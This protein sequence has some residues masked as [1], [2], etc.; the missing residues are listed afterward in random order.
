MQIAVIISKLLTQKILIANAHPF[1]VFAAQCINQF[2]IT[3]NLQIG[4]AK[5]QH[6]NKF[7]LIE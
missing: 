3:L 7:N 1:R 4:N 2:L 6:S 5:Y